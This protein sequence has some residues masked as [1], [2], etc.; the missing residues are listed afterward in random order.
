VLHALWVEWRDTVIRN[1]ALIGLAG[2][3][4]IE[5]DSHAEFADTFTPAHRRMSSEERRAL[6]ARV[7]AG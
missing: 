7:A 2:G 6:V 5:P 1:A 3:K 4:D